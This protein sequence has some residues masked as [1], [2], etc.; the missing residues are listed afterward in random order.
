MREKRLSGGWRAV[1]AVYGRLPTT[2]RE[3]LR[4]GVTLPARRRLAAADRPDPARVSAKGASA[5]A[6]T[7]GEWVLGILLER[8]GAGEAGAREAAA[9]WQDDRVVFWAPREA[10]PGEGV[11]FLWRIRASSPA[12]AA[13]IARLLAPLY[14][15]R[16]AAARPSVSARGDLVEVSRAPGRPPAG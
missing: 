11:G 10:P 6:D 13:R 16:P 9:G 3:I 14:A 5:W 15:E 8:A 7:L 1:D 2:T 4:P 12:A